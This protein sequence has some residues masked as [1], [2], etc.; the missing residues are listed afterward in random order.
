MII[1]KTPKSFASTFS[2]SNGGISGALQSSS[3]GCFVRV[4]ESPRKKNIMF[5]RT[6]LGLR[7]LLYSESSNDLIL[8]LLFIYL[9]KR[10][11]KEAGVEDDE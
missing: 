8:F 1:I 11:P 2:V 4:L 9:F 10:K 7:V 3:S 5:C 6:A